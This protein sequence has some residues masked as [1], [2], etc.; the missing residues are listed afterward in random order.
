MKCGEDEKIFI[1]VL[2]LYSS[3]LFWHLMRPLF[4]LLAVLS[5][6][7]KR[8]L[9]AREKHAI[10]SQGEDSFEIDDAGSFE[11]LE[12]RFDLSTA[13]VTDLSSLDSF[14]EP[15]ALQTHAK[16]QLVAEK[17]AEEVKAQGKRRQKGPRSLVMPAMLFGSHKSEGF[18]IPNRKAPTKVRFS[19]KRVFG[20][21]KLASSSDASE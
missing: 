4:H 8:A 13:T 10:E 9:E 5:W 2:N 17:K 11:E 12:K 16:K 1:I 18:M 7:D 15:E 14:E 3:F 19:H 6:K 20:N 21:K